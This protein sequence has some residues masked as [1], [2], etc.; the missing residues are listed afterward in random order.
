MLFFDLSFDLLCHVLDHLQHCLLCLFA[1]LSLLL[2]S[3]NTNPY[4]VIYLGKHSLISLLSLVGLGGDKLLQPWH[5]ILKAAFQLFNALISVSG[6]LA[7]RLPNSHEFVL[8]LL[9]QPRLHVLSS[10]LFLVELFLN[11]RLQQLNFFELHLMFI[12]SCLLI[13]FYVF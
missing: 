1:L 2:H 8:Y 11:I 5:V 10:Q 6:L 13:S 3:I 9:Q 4:L 12:V 7:Q